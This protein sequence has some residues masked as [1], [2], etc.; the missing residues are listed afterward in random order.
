MPLKKLKIGI[1][2]C[3]LG[4][5]YRYDGQSKLDRRVVDFLLNK[6]EFV[7]ICPEVECGLPIPRPK[8]QL[9]RSV[10]GT[11]LKVID[12]G[13]DLTLQMET[14][15]E[16]KLEQI[17]R[18]DLAAFLCKSKSPSCALKSAKLF[19]ASGHCMMQN[20]PGIFVRMLKRRF[21]KMLICEETE[22][23]DF[24]KHLNLD[25]FSNSGND[26]TEHE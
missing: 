4:M 19:D 16:G 25:I 26:T 11:R 22:L 5:R 1:S 23:E 14:W 13:E 15:G 3:L 6:V 18:R 24:V 2:A 12:S 20:S 8:M 21:P 17:E 7:P 9:E 10:R